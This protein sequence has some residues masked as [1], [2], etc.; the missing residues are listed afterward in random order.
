[1]PVSLLAQS[2]DVTFKATDDTS[3]IDSVLATNLATDQ[4]ILF[5]GNETLL[6]GQSAGLDNSINRGSNIELFP[7]P[8]SSFLNLSFYSP[9]SGNISITIR[10][11]LGQELFQHI[12][13]AQS[14]RQ[15]FV[16]SMNDPGVFFISISGPGINESDK[17]IHTGLSQQGFGVYS[18]V[19]EGNSLHN[20]KLGSLSPDMEYRLAYSPGQTMH[21]TCYSGSNTT[22]LTDSP[23]SSVN[24][25]I[26]FIECVDKDGMNYDVVKIGG[27][28]WMAENLAYLPFLG[29]N[30]SSNYNCAVYNYPG[31]IVA[32]AKETFNYQKYGVLYD[33]DSISDICPNGWVIP[34]KEDFETL[35]NFYGKNAITKLKSRTGWVDDLNGDNTSGF[36][37]LPGGS[38]GERW[39]YHGLG[40]RTSFWIGHM[41]NNGYWIPG[42][43]NID[44]DR[45]YLDYY[46]YN[47]DGYSVRCIHNI[48]VLTHHPLKITDHSVL[49]GGTVTSF[50]EG[51]VSCIGGV[52]WST[53]EYPDITLNRTEEEVLQ[54]RIIGRMSNL[55]AGTRYFARAYVLTSSGRTVYGNQVT[56]RTADGSFIDER[57]G[58]E[59]SY[60][61]IGDLYWMTDNL[62][63]LPKVDW[64]KDGSNNEP[65]YYVYGY[66]N[67]H[68]EEAKEM[69]TYNT[70]GVLYNWPAATSECPA[71]WY[72]PTDQDWNDMELFAG[73]KNLGVKLKSILWRHD[74]EKY[75]G[76]LTRIGFNALPA[77]RRIYD[78]NFLDMNFNYQSGTA[79]LWT[80]TPSSSVHSDQEALLRRI[81][82]NHVNVERW[83]RARDH[84]FSVRCVKKK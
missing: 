38:R 25:S 8:F 34:K 75:D 58:R 67:Y 16:L 26:E 1:M 72:L 57:D 76:D 4:S 32:E 19:S 11:L 14:G 64:K 69:D 54:G 20:K 42:G 31:R 79:F 71:G 43:L 56:F 59:Y 35:L 70:F 41:S 9:L 3:V 84:A 21:Y 81:D 47:Y 80:S 37:A 45:N 6:L 73:L 82:H 24:Y 66:N 65:R 83:S 23:S 48:N 68:V 18:S 77:G 63:Y 60:V 2:I 7:N 28:M 33:I 53:S 62:A 61:S 55:E 74:E 10:N 17:A 50:S 40:E 12:E 36:N 5:P 52:C 39:T 78:G 44:N 49:A 13:Y 22:I 15:S 29:W 46:N 27:Q 30:D 51:P